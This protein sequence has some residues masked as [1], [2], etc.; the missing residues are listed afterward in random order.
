MRKP[1]D[2]V[3]QALTVERV[4][5]HPRE[6]VFRAWTEASRLE[7]WF[8]PNPQNRI[9]AKVDLR[10][11][12]SYRIAMIPPQGDGWVVGGLYRE[13]Q[14]PSRLS[15]TWKWEDSIEEASLVGV[16]FEE[17]DSGTRVRVNHSQLESEESVQSHREGWS[18]I[19]TRLADYCDD[20]M[21]WQAPGPLDLLTAGLQVEYAKKLAELG[22]LRIRRA[23]EFVPADKR[24]WAPSSTSKS[25]QRIAAHCA[26][27][28]R[29]FA[30]ILR[31]DQAPYRTARELAGEVYEEEACLVEWN[32]TLANLEEANSEALEAFEHVDPK[33][34]MSDG[35]VAFVLS[36]MGRHA[37][38]HAGQLEYLQTVW[39]DTLDHF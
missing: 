33:R 36:L 16:D 7:K 11:G 31:G 21:E 20:I 32:E 1:V 24:H 39:G 28:N 15:F 18:G 19:L 8:S 10:I 30:A 27:A 25:A 23:L 14:K 6:I 37:D 38:G 35:K 9:V 13:I 17:T 3:I 29:R 5:A 34:L 4:Y 22:F 26:V 2:S 12:G